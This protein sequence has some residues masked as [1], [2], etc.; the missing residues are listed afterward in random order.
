MDGFVT[1]KFLL[2]HHFSQFFCPKATGS[3]RSCSRLC[4]EVDAAGHAVEAGVVIVAAAGRGY[5]LSACA[6]VSLIM[7][8]NGRLLQAR[9]RGVIHGIGQRSA[10]AAGDG[11]VGL[12]T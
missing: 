1:K 11:V 6:G 5:T 8:P 4:G 2:A 12:R 7:I 10:A 9:Q 3:G